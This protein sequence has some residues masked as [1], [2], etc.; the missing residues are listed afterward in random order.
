MRTNFKFVPREQ[1]SLTR[2]KTNICVRRMYSHKQV[3]LKL[4]HCVWISE[5]LLLDVCPGPCQKKL[6]GAT[7][8]RSRE[9]FFAY[10]KMHC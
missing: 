5:N 3:S 9:G 1:E 7:I 6:A 10:C 4:Y 2:T 8:H